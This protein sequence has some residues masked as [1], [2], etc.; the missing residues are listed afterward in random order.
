MFSDTGPT[1][2]GFTRKYQKDMFESL[3][4]WQDPLDQICTKAA[5]MKVKT[6]MAKPKESAMIEADVPLGEAIHQLVLGHHQS[7]LVSKDNRV[8]GVL[9]LT[10]AFE[11]VSEAILACSR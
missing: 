5:Q 8:V 4:L 2:M 3:K 7:L 11:F 10:D 1:H 9:R 6:F